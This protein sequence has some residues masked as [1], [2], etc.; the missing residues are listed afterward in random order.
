M[1]IPQ[2]IAT[3]LAFPLW[4]IALIQPNVIVCPSR[5]DV[6]EDPELDEV[7][8]NMSFADISTKNINIH[9]IYIYIHY[10]YTRSIFA[11]HQS[12]PPPDSPPWA[13]H[14]PLGLKLWS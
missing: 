8:Q 2:K 14:G 9:I 1:R 6:Q 4:D 11:P 12:P 13:G 10:V 7:L 3:C 5:L